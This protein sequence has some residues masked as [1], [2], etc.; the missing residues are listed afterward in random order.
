VTSAPP[1]VDSSPDE[2]KPARQRRGLLEDHQAFRRRRGARVMPRF[3]LGL[4][5]LS[6]KTLAALNS[7]RLLEYA[8]SLSPS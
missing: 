3:P 8:A 5:S 7:K 1:F 2:L 4:A 6:V